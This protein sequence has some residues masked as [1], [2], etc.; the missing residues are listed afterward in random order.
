MLGLIRKD[1]L[2]YLGHLMIIPLQ[3][4]YWHTTRMQL[5]T[6]V[7]FLMTG[8]LYIVIIGSIFSVEM[9]ETRNRGYSFLATLPL[10]AREIVGA[11]LIPI[12]VIKAVYVLVTY[13]SFSSLE[14][15]PAYLALS[16]KWLL[17]NAGF[18]LGVAGLIYWSVF[19]YGTARAI[20]LQGVLFLFAFIVPIALNELVT[21]GYLNDSSAIF[22]LA[23]TTGNGF[24]L[25]AGAVVFLVSYY[26][27][28]RTYERETP[29]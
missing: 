23:R 4:A 29:A 3:M 13:F 22:R 10:S 5:D 11:R 19:R 17:F 6:T 18:A 26:I 7:V 24:L 2:F 15:E 28:V 14:V 21:R 27:S 9:N 20:Y 16:R 1:I 25:V 8:W 12:F